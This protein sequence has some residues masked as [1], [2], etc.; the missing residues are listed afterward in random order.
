L[1]L[2]GYRIGYRINEDQDQNLGTNQDISGL[3]L[4]ST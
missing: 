1:F 3:F 4:E 2:M